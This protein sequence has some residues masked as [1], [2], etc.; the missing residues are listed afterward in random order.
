[1][2]QS[3][4]SA[5]VML[6]VV[7]LS[8]H[9]RYGGGFFCKRGTQVRILP[10]VLFSL[11][12]FFFEYVGRY[13]KYPLLKKRNIYSNTGIEVLMKTETM[14]KIRN[15]ILK[16]LRYIMRRDIWG[17][18]KSHG[19]CY[20]NRS[21]GHTDNVCVWMAEQQRIPI[22]KCQQVCRITKKWKK[23]RKDMFF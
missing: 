11:Y 17:N 3:D 5:T 10:E 14:K 22:V 1:M 16:D 19:V 12:R 23:L 9:A 13:T 15:K 7:E 8:K 20:I 4:M 21:N 18:F 2:F 6:S